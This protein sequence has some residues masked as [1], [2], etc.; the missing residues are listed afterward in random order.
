M[1]GPIERYLLEKIKTDEAIRL[2]EA[3]HKFKMEE[4][5]VT[6]PEPSMSAAPSY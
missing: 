2:E 3:K 4:L 6:K 1:V 5:Q